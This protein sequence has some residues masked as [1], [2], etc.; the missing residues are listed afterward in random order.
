MLAHTTLDED[1]VT[2]LRGLL[3]LL[4]VGMSLGACATMDL[5]PSPERP[6]VSG[7][8]IE[9]ALSAPIAVFADDAQV[10]YFVRLDGAEGLQRSA[11][12]PSTLATGGRAYLLNVPAGEYAAVAA[13][14]GTATPGG[15]TLGTPD[16][17]RTLT[18]FS[19]EIVEGTRVSVEPGRFAFMGRLDVDSSVGFD[20]A[21]PTQLYYLDVLAPGAAKSTGGQILSVGDNQ[22]PGTLGELQRDE[23]TLSALRESAAEDIADSGWT[24]ILGAGQ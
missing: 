9:V 4:V 7:L 13:R 12:I 23:A 8:A 10:V 24:E 2:R 16:M 11:V 21:D 20:E 18:V 5:V 3:L 6:E 1:A 14:A 17:N 22:Y 19:S 15:I